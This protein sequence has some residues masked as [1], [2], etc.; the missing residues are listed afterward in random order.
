MAC[1]K[2]EVMTCDRCGYHDVVGSSAKN[3]NGW[4]EIGLVRSQMVRTFGA[5]RIT[6]VS[7]QHWVCPACMRE[8][9]KLWSEYNDRVSEWFDS[10]R[11]KGG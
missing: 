11:M 3:R 6:Q 7:E 9:T 2:A 8:A 1:E 4:G 10:L 5:D